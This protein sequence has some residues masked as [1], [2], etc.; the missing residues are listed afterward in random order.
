MCIIPHKANNT[1]IIGRTSKS[2]TKKAANIRTRMTGE[3]NVN[4]IHLLKSCLIGNFSSPYGT[5]NDVLNMAKHK[6]VI[7]V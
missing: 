4:P 5:L 1:I 7:I 3:N 2:T 6:P